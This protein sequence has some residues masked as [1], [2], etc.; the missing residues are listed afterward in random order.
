M[1]STLKLHNTLTGRLETI[2]APNNI[3]RIYL[4]GITVYDES[5][6]GHAR[7]II[8]FD[9]LNRFIRS[10]GY[11]VQLVQNF[12]DIDDKIINRARKEGLRAKDIAL[13]YI[14]DY[15]RDFDQLN[16]LRADHYPRATDHIKDIIEMIQRLIEKKHAYISLNGIYFHVK[17][18]IEYGKLSKK[19]IEELESGARVE[20]DTSKHDPLDFALWKFYSDEPLW[21]SPWG[22]GRPGWHIEC[23]AMALKYLGN[24]IEI[25]CGGQDLIFPHHE[26]EIAQ[27]EAYSGKQFVKLWMHSGMVTT[28]TEKMSKSIGNVVSIQQ[29]IGEF[30][31]N[32][33]RIFCLSTKYSKPLD[34]TDKLLKESRQKWRQIE[35][36]AYELRCAI[37]NGGELKKMEILSAETMKSFESALD[38]NLNTPLALREF[39]KFVTELNRLAASD[40]L[41]REISEFCSVF[42]TKMMYI[43]GLRVTET[44]DIEKQHIEDLII[45]RNKLRDEKKFDASDMI[46]KR[47]IEEYSVELMDHKNRTTWKKLEKV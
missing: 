42:F 32:T 23:S 6:I 1:V 22:K 35:T 40:K 43:L 3:I 17:S 20:V 14:N 9:T 15:F 4:C 37:S 34:Y 38:N 24:S 7:T 16:I 8:V 19:S 39:M 2:C 12:T 21:D 26:N 33:L 18:F 29:A 47:L 30:G 36:C 41:T 46:R 25:H 31:I 44:T 27:S 5:H 45:T 28:N 10:K 11:K 13:R